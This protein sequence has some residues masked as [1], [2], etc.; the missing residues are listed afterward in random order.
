MAPPSSAPSAHLTATAVDDD[1]R[2]GSDGRGGVAGADDA[3]DAALAGDDGGVTEAATD[4]GDDPG[5]A[6]DPHDD[7]GTGHLGDNDAV[8]GQSAVVGVA[9]HDRG[10]ARG[11]TGG[12]GDAPGE[13]AIVALRISSCLVAG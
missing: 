7:L 3:G 6:L 2:P 4:V 8:G 9:P 10:F 11:Q 12:S 1:E 13:N 5:D